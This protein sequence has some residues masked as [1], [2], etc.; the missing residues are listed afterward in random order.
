MSGNLRPTG[1]ALVTDKVFSGDASDQ[2]YVNHQFVRLVAKKRRFTNCDFSYSEFESAYLRSCV[3]DSCKFIGCKFTKSNLRGS[4]F[5]GCS[6]DY[7]EFSHTHVEPELLKTGCP[8]HEN[9]Q[10]KFARTLRVNYQQIGD[11]VA[12]NEAIEVELDA[13]KVHLFKAWRS[14][15]S[16]YRKKYVG[17]GSRLGM[18]M[19]WIRFVALDFYWGNG[20][21]SWKLLRSIMILLCVVASGDLLVLRDARLPASYA[22]ATATA[23]EVILGVSKPPEYSG[24]LVALITAVRYVTIACLVSILVKRLGR[25]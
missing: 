1:R 6:F 19:E 18:F 24:V 7:A 14:R 17:F 10:Q 13:T 22:T 3:F 25:R 5:I 16:Y 4:S 20:E 8:G 21:S 15:E 23:L 9:L 12:V 2:K 11:A